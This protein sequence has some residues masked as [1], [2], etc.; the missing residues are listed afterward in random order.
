MNKDLRNI[1]R[2]YGEDMMHLCRKLFPTILE[3]EGELF[4]ILNG[5]FSYNKYLY[6]DLV[7]ND[8]VML[9]KDYIYQKYNNVIIKSCNDN[10]TPYQL[11][12]EADYNLYECKTE[13]DIQKFKKYYYDDEKIC[14]FNGGR[15]NS[16][17]VFFA[18]KK[19]VDKIIRENFKNPE[20]EDEYGTS[21]ISIQ[22]SRG[23]YNTLSIKNRYNDTVE[24]PDATFSNNLDNII[25]GL[26]ESFAKYYNL[27]ENGSVVKF[28]IPGYVKANNGKYYKYNYKLNGVYYCTDNIIIK[29]YNVIDEYIDKEKYI[30]MD[31]FIVDLVNKTVK[32]F[33][34]LDDSFVQRFKNIKK[35]DI[36]KNS[37]GK[38]L[39]F[40]SDDN[41]EIVIE[42][43]KY[44]QMI[45]YS[46]EYATTCDCNFLVHDKYIKELS[47]PNVIYVDDNFMLNNE[48]LE[49][50]NLIKLYAVG[51]HFLA[52]N[53]MI[54]NID[55]PELKYIDT[56]F[57]AVNNKIKSIYLPNVEHINHYFMNRNNSVMEI[58]MP[59]VKKISNYFMSSNKCIN[60]VE[61]PNL[62]EVGL[63]FLCF[64]QEL[65]MLRLN[66]LIKTD[67][68]FLDY[69]RKIKNVYFPNLQFVGLN[70]MTCNESL[71]TISL[72][73]IIEIENGFL[74]SNKC[75]KEFIAPNLKALGANSLYSNIDLKY[76]VHSIKEF[77]SDILV[78]NEIFG[79]YFNL[80]EK[81]LNKI[82]N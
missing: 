47:M 18:V 58:R 68:N 63:D 67:D 2:H 59:K 20:R 73:S 75:L 66:S 56:C 77:G 55:F 30:L 69:N 28:E 24:N 65:T 42:L 16:N 64:N 33:D 19:N 14:T 36:L 10:K 31:Y 32:T 48:I 46:D 70:F 35:I 81:K 61:M 8:K 72:P 41:Q 29:E 12:D 13:E 38:V 76:F 21:V 79:C 50:I 62:L 23:R 80:N 74:F 44:N 37:D 78:N 1:K 9:F 53:M 54:D 17:Y 3:K 43:N 51:K 7:N 45:K 40:I 5:N 34:N 52:Y 25:P 60:F 27:S 4:K 71:E 22:F 15:L 6:N 11:L 82:M 49:K 57:M 26:S 39:K